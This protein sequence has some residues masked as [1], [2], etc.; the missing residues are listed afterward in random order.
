MYNPKTHPPIL[1]KNNALEDILK[2]HHKS[3]NYYADIFNLLLELRDL[4]VRAYVPEIVTTTTGP[5]SWSTSVQ[6][7]FTTIDMLRLMVAGG[8]DIGDKVL[9]LR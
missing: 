4:G 5:N 3:T 2:G 8:G 7:N 6:L 1:S 9:R